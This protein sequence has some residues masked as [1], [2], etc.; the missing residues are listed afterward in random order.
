VLE[1]Q[2]SCR[3]GRI[4]AEKLGAVFGTEM[5]HVVP[6]YGSVGEVEALLEDPPPPQAVR[7]IMTSTQLNTQEFFV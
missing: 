6:A 1:P 3:A 7:H 4:S 5:G 2:L